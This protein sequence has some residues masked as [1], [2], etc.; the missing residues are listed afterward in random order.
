MSSGRSWWSA[1][2]APSCSPRPAL[3]SLDAPDRS[4]APHATSQIVYAAKESCSAGRLRLGVIPTLAPYVLPL[5]L[6]E[7][8]RNHPDLR[9]D[10]LETQTKT[11][12][13]ELA[14]GTMDVLLL[15]LPHR[16]RP[17]S[18]RASCSSD[19]FLLAVPA[20]DPLPERAR[21]STRDV[22]ARR[23]VLLEEGHCLRDQALIYCGEARPRTY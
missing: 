1:V 14:Q 19:R 21:V 7:L 11:L 15:A 18:K 23:L 2:K 22:N 16:E 6:P 4:S 3:R 17:S 12:V 20:D 8:H 9:L 13:S 10:L 5:L